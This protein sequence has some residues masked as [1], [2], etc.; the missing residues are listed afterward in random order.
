M[1]SRTGRD[2]FGGFG[3]NG[4]ENFFMSRLRDRPQSATFG[5]D[6]SIVT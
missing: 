1:G 3:W 4:M 5:K 2:G 6:K